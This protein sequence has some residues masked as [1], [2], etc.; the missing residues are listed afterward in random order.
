MANTCYVVPQ[1]DG[2]RFDALY[3]RNAEESLECMTDWL[4][5]F[6]VKNWPLKRKA[7]DCPCTLVDYITF[8]GMLL[9][10]GSLGNITT[11]KPDSTTLTIVQSHRLGT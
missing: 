2:N 4:N 9:N 8:A 5:R 1:A 3:R 11:V 7:L 10:K 6:K